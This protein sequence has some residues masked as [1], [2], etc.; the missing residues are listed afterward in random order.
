MKGLRVIQVSHVSDSG[1][2]LLDFRVCIQSM[3]DE[4]K[5]EPMKKKDSHVMSC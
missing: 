4:I 2:N 5:L 1:K 3:V